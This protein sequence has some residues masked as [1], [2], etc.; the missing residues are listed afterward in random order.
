MKQRPIHAV[1]PK[2]YAH[3]YK[4]LTLCG[5]LVPFGGLEVRGERAVT[6]KLCLKMRAQERE[7]MPA[8]GF[9]EGDL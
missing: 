8:I 7:K 9:C 3:P 6:C 1:S 4:A 5:K 2:G